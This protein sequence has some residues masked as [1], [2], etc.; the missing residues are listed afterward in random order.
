VTEPIRVLI[1]RILYATDFS[2]ASVSALP[3]A[4]A[5]AGKHDAKIYAAH[6]SPERIGLP[7]SVCEGLQ[8][9]GAIPAREDLE[10][11]KNLEAQLRD[12]PHEILLRKGD[13]WAELSKIIG[14]ENFD[15]VVIGTHG[16]SGVG[17]LL[18]G[19]VAEKIFRHTPGPVL[20][21]GPAVSGEP[22]S[23]ADVHAILFPTDFGAESLAAL[24]YAISLAQT[25]KARL[26]LLH[27]AKEPGQT[28]TVLKTKLR[29][30]IPPDAEFFCQPKVLIEFGPPAEQILA[31]A[32]ELGTDLVVLG[33]K[34]SPLFFEPSD[35]FP[36][37]TAYKVVTHALCP[38][39]TV[40]GRVSR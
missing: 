2:R 25:Q 10:A 36:Q 12:V 38:V 15:L 35:H 37:A 1:K 13:V 26:Y 9:M 29:S 7:T 3:Y 19:S 32:E 30:L 5:L 17:K 20:T 22:E 18:M 6:V 31:L 8:A 16:R 40:R 28:E 33:V 34:R 14:E 39:L 21:V 24:P 23:V 27:I 4:L 11:L